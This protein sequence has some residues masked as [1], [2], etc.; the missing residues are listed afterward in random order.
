MIPRVN[1]VERARLHFEQGARAAEAN[2][3]GAAVDGFGAAAL[4]NPGRSEYE[5]RYGE[6]L[7]RSGRFIDGLAALRS[8]IELSPDSA[9]YVL[10]V[11][12]LET[13]AGDDAA[14]LLHL[15]SYTEL[16]PADVVGHS[17]RA[18][19]L[20]KLDRAE[21]AALSLD[22]ASDL[23]AV[24][25]ALREAMER[26]HIASG[27]LNAANGAGEAALLSYRNALDANPISDE[28]RGLILDLEQAEDIES[29]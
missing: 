4:L 12:R 2:R 13:S 17:D 11:A 8:A 25:A 14:A 15:D 29:E 22:I 6:A 3:W 10:W 7:V 21:E 9:S 20:L 19:V 26:F 28:A 27:M 16:R 23:V 1:Q 24:G 5:Y 18:I